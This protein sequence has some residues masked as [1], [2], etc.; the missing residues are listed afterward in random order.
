[1]PTAGLAEAF[2]ASDAVFFT[3]GLDGFLADAG[4]LA[5]GFFTGFFVVAILRYPP[6]L[7][8]I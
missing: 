6:L 8:I 7:L 4:F 5:A 3:A 2:A 1:L